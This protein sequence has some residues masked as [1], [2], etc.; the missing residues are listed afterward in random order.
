M[1]VSK[2]RFKRK[3]A[4]RYEMVK[5]TT[6]IYEGEFTLPDQKHFTLGIAES[7]NKG[8]V[9]VLIEWLSESVKVDADTVDAIRDL[10]QEELQPF[11]EA[12]SKGSV[13]TLPKSSD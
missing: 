7:L 13:V 6:D 9:G 10:D 3:N 4:K 1:P 8:D 12:W 5:F 11:I 2:T